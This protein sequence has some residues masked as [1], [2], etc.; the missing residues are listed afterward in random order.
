MYLYA[1]VCIIGLSF[2]L[3]NQ[4]TQWHTQQVMF[5]LFTRLVA[6]FNVSFSTLSILKLIRMRVYVCWHI[7]IYKLQLQHAADAIIAFQSVKPI[8]IFICMYVCMSTCNQSHLSITLQLLYVIVCMS[9]CIGAF[10]AINVVICHFGDFL[11]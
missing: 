1:G 3:R 5:F 7:N 11:G 4:A 2:F 10:V 9:M 8:N 6:Y